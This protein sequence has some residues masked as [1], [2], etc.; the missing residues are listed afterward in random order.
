MDKAEEYLSRV[1]IFSHMKKDD[2]K[3]LAGR[4][5]MHSY[6]K[7]DLVFREGDKD[8]RL[9]VIVNGMVDVVKDLGN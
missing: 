6:Q 8:G 7:G 4:A 3:R 5:R 1:S 2:L 9:F